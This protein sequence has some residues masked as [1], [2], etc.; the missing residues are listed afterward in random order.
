[1]AVLQDADASPSTSSAHG[2][3]RAELFTV[4]AQND[5]SEQRARY[6]SSAAEVIC[7]RG[8][9]MLWHTGLYSHATVL[10]AS[11]SVIALAL[12]DCTLLTLWPDGSQMMCPAALRARAVLLHVRGSQVT[13]VLAN[14][15][16]T[17]W[18]MSHQVVRPQAL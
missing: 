16:V 4:T 5:R 11:E 18:D 9:S 15:D 14:G 1:M 8:N 2:S 3:S 6:G 13:A 10:A 7:S 12:Q 17:S